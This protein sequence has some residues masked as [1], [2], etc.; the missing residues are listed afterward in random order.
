MHMLHLNC[1]ALS[2]GLAPALGGAL[3]YFRSHTDSKDI[4][5]MRPLGDAEASPYNC[6]SFVMV[7]FFSR[8]ESDDFQFGDRHVALPPPAPGFERALHGLG[9]GAT[10]Q[11][12]AHTE[13]S[14][15]LSHRNAGGA[16]PWR[17][18]AE[19][20]ITL[21]EQGM[22]IALSLRNEDT[23]PMPAGIGIHPFFPRPKGLR[24]QANLRAMHLMSPL[25]LPTGAE[26]DNAALRE[27]AQ[28]GE[29]PRDLDNVFQG[30]DG[31]ASLTGPHGRLSM[32][33]DAAFG[34]MCIYGPEEK[35]FCCVEPVS[36]TTNALHAQH[37]AGSETGYLL[38]QPGASLTGTVRFHP[39]L[40]L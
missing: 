35:P 30:W 17:Y 18:L 11:V 5:W 4:D 12:D 32:T 39:E 3:T 1:G 34:F 26:H 40:A 14:A 13:H 22:T 25:G 33:A 28:G 6:A 36:H 21:D 2:A 31:V 8:L 29:L 16:W 20:T 7:P 15:T 9:W 23:V 38:L 37:M 19:Q 10:W 27:L 24:V